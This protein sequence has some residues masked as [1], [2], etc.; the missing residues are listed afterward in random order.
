MANLYVCR[1]WRAYTLLFGDIFAPYCSLAIRQLTH[2][3]HEN[4]PRGSP[5]PRRLN[6]KGE[7]GI[8]PHI[9]T[10]GYL[11]SWW[12]SCFITYD[13]YTSEHAL[14][15]TILQ[16]ISCKCSKSFSFWG[17]TPCRGY[18]PLGPHW[19]L[20]IPRSP[21]SIKW[22]WAPLLQSTVVFSNDVCSA[23]NSWRTR[24]RGTDSWLDDTD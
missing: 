4:R 9:V 20:P 22:Q 7:S 8:S 18:F 16:N 14:F 24:I 5:P 2:Q 12:V 6:T 21:N 19:G 13:I 15:I 1:L 17:T 10:F 3:N 23:P 11:V